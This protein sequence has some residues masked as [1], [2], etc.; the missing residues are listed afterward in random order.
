MENMLCAYDK[1]EEIFKKYN[2]KVL[3]D[4]LGYNIRMEFYKMRRMSVN[5]LIANGILKCPDD[6]E[7]TTA[8]MYVV[9]G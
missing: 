9:L 2:H 8:L 3:H 5:D 4:N 6:P 7:N 1:V